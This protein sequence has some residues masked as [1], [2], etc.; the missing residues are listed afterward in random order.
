LNPVRIKAHSRKDTKE[1]KAVL[2][3]FRH[4]SFRGYIHPGKRDDFMNY[5][6]VLNYFGGDHPEGRRAYQAFV[7]KGLL[8]PGTPL[9][10]GRG[11]GIIGSEEFIEKIRD[12][13]LAKRTAQNQREQPHLKEIQK[14]YQ[15]EALI[16]KFCDFLNLDR[17]HICTRG[18]NSVERSIL[19][20]L[21][22]RYCKIT[23]PEIG[24]L[25]GG[26]DYSAVSYARKRLREKMKKDNKIR[27]LFESVEVELSRIKI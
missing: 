9:G 17:K 11:S 10:I 6:T 26:I 13:Y 16:K 25:V 21:L 19:M 24:R 8:N 3:N 7:E 1:K 14:K 5:S 18:R 27:L 22:Y 20:E 12:A 23:Q 15:P 2:G 4:S